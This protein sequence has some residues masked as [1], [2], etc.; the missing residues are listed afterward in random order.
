M[1]HDLTGARRH[2]SLQNGG[3]VPH[4]AGL[5][6]GMEMGRVR[7]KGVERGGRTKGKIIFY[8]VV[9]AQMDSV[10]FGGAM[11]WRATK[12]GH[13]GKS[14]GVGGVG[15]AGPAP[16][17]VGVVVGVGVHAR[18]PGGW[19]MPHAQ[20]TAAQRVLDLDG[21]RIGLKLHK[22]ARGLLLQPP[23]AGPCGVFTLGR[24]TIVII[25]G[26]QGRVGEMGLAVQEV[27]AVVVLDDVPCRRVGQGG[28][29]QQEQAWEEH[30][31][32]KEDPTWLCFGLLKN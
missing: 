12:R 27:F 25:E 24:Q 5:V 1:R 14:G 18:D 19:K 20:S 26:A 30:C 11:G 16:R 3:T 13:R 29:E 9:G 22:H 8:F 28:E 31:G 4:D 7:H 32:G 2:G 21:G 15:G 10:G 17:V 6:D 23:D